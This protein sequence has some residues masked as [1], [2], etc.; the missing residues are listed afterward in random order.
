LVIVTHDGLSIRF[1]E[2]DVRAT[3]RTTRGVK[4]ITLRNGD[5]VVGACVV[6][7]GAKLLTV[8]ENGYGKKTEFAEYRPQSRGGKG[9][10]T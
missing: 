10:Y 3:G 2:T 8:T 4:A 5:Y 7:D 9:I 6:T 1:K